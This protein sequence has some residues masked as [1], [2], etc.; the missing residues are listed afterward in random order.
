MASNPRQAGEVRLKKIEV[1]PEMN[2]AGVDCLNNLPLEDLPE[3][4]GPSPEQLRNAMSCVF[5]AMHEIYLTNQSED[6]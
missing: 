2:E 5:S 6:C 4:L 1:T 3:L